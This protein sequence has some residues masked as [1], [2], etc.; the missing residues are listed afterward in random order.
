MAAFEITYF[1][2]KDNNEHQINIEYDGPELSTLDTW[3]TGA[4]MAVNWCN[5]N[6]VCLL[7]ITGICM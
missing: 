7:S 4:A 3:K 2:A 6:N 5:E 1:D